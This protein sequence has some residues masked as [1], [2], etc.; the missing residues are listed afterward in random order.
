MWRA[1]KSLLVLR[2]QIDV[3]APN[4]DRRSDGLVGDEDHQQNNPGSGHNPHPVPG[5]GDEM[6]TALD[7]THDPA[8]GCDTYVLSEALRINRDRRIRYVISNRRIFSSYASGS[9]AAWEWG[10]YDGDDPHDTH[11]HTQVLDSAISDTT[12]PWNLEGFMSNPANDLLIHNTAWMLQRGVI[13]LRD[14]IIIP[15]D[16][17]VAN[18]G[19]TLANPLAQFIKGIKADITAIK[20]ELASGGTG[21]GGTGDDDTDVLAKLE[22]VEKRVDALVS[23]VAAQADAVKASLEQ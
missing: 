17:N 11:S 16:A 3:I 8:H 4:R 21:G 14:P 18:S 22:D 12:T 9:R 20:D 10:P 7:L 15:K 1:M 5:V 6:V 19:A 2:A 23:G 13:E